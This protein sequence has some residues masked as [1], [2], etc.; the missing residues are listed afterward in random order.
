MCNKIKQNGMRECNCVFEWVLGNQIED[1]V[2]DARMQLFLWVGFRKPNWRRTSFSFARGNTCSHRNWCRQFVN[3][4]LKLEE[5]EEYTHTP[6]IFYSGLRTD[7]DFKV[8]FVPNYVPP[9]PPLPPAT[10]P[11]PTPPQEQSTAKTE[12]FSSLYDIYDAFFDLYLC[13]LRLT[14]NVFDLWIRKS[15]R[16]V[17]T[18]CVFE[19]V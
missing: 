4:I 12:R 6:P 13:V 14:K 3:S 5:S 19:W 1:G 18:S 7:S 2:R 10:T 17:C 8:S 9:V 15:S 16:N 11:P